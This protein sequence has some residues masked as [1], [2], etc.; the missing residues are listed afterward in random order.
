MIGGLMSK[1]RFLAFILFCV[2][3]SLSSLFA[4]DAKPDATPG[5]IQLKL[6]TDEADAVLA[7]LDKST[8]GSAVTDSDWQRLFSTEPYNRLKKREAGMHRDFTDDDFKKF[9]LSPNWQRRPPSCGTR[10]TPGGR[11]IWP[12]RQ[13]ECSPTFRTRLISALKCSP[14]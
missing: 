12:L 2:L 1:S 13:N 8:A 7:I 10:S 6:N 5:S 4:H 14:L 11:P 3:G 9:V